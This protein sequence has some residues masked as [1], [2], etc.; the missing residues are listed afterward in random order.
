MQATNVSA[1]STGGSVSKGTEEFL[2]VPLEV[3][4]AARILAAHFDP[5]ELY[6]A[7]VE[8]MRRR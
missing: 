2:R 3:E 6:W 1:G 8:E 5:D 4:D 7:M